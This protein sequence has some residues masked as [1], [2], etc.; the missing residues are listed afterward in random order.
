MSCRSRAGET[1]SALRVYQIPHANRRAVIM[2]CSEPRKEDEG[3]SALPVADGADQAL[4]RPR[5]GV[6]SRKPGNLLEIREKIDQRLAL[7]I[8]EVFIAG[9]LG[10]GIEPPGLLQDHRQLFPGQ[11]SPDA[12]Q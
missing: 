3:F 5:T 7:G 9:H 1:A 11:A 10:A 8:R 4:G 12:R 6:E 2:F